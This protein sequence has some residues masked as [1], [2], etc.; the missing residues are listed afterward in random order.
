[1]ATHSSILAWRSTWTVWKAKKIWQQKMRWLHSIT[2]S[3]D[4]N[5]SKLWETVKDREAWCAAVHGVAKSQTQ[6]RD[7]ITLTCYSLAYYSIK[8]KHVKTQADFFSLNIPSFILVY[9]LSGVWLFVTSWTAALP[10]PSLSPRVCSNS[11]A[12]SQ[13]CHPIISSSVAPFSSCFLFFFFNFILFLNF[14]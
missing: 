5:L 10:R 11:C 9:S 1:M 8:E 2:N 13:W 12:L 7:W 4:V 14:T 3:M 6:L